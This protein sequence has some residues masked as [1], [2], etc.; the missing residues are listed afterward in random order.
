M[1]RFFV[2]ALAALFL[3]SC[4]DDSGGDNTEPFVPEATDYTY[5]LSQSTDSVTIWT[6]PATHRIS[7][8]ERA[9]EATKSGIF[10]SLARNEYEPFQ[11]ILEPGR[12]DCSVATEGLQLSGSSSFTLAKADFSGDRLDSLTPI[13]QGDQVQSDGSLVF[14]FT[15]YAGQ[16]AEAGSHDA[17]ITLTCKGVEIQIPVEIYV[18]DFSLPEGASFATQ[19]NI[20]VSSLI[21]EGERSRMPKTSSSPTA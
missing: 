17:S 5:K 7:P 16:D 9:P 14:W 2:L 21:P 4:D 18:F 13:S 8:N 11:L 3:L 20:S 15:L 1:K 19:L 10:V 12:G 6:T